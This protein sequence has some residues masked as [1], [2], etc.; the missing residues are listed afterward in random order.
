[1]EAVLLVSIVLVFITIVVHSRNESAKPGRLYNSQTVQRRKAI[2]RL[3]E[4]QTGAPD[5]EHM[6]DVINRAGFKNRKGR[7]FTAIMI[8]KEHAEMLLNKI[9]PIQ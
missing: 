2:Q 8:K 1:M 3:I 5:W 7:K 9:E 6:T 4:E